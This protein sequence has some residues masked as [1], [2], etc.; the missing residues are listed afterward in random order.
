ME[1]LDIEIACDTQD[2]ELF[3]KYLESLGHS[4]IIG[5]S[6]GNYID[7]VRTRGETDETIIMNKMYE[8]FCCLS[9]DEYLKLDQ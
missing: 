1:K 4:A 2:A 6:D 3:I 9:K 5:D 8:D 7:G